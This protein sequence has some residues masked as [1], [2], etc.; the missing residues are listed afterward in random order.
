MQMELSRLTYHEA[1]FLRILFGELD[2]NC[3]G[4]ISMEECPDPIKVFLTKW[5]HPSRNGC[6][7]KCGADKLVV[8]GI[9]MATGVGKSLRDTLL[10]ISSIMVRAVL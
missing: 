10:T 1:G 3:D 9:R 6:R 2:T 8:A 4:I 5:D 7:I